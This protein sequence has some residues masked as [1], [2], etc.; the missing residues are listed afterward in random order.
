MSDL[1]QYFIK[2][3]ILKCELKEKY[4]I[5]SFPYKTKTKGEWILATTDSL[6]FE[7]D[8]MISYS[9]SRGQELLNKEFGILW[10]SESTYKQ[11]QRDLDT[12]AKIPTVIPPKLTKDYSIGGRNFKR[13]CSIKGPLVVHQEIKKE[14]LQCISQRVY[15]QPLNNEEISKL[16]A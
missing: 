2:L 14:R 6:A 4:Q 7:N 13:V 9:E 3:N 8:E 10:I 15:I 5:N 12:Q 1:K 11:F 16:V